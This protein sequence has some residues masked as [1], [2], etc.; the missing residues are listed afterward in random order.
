MD[1]L[2]LQPL[3]PQEV[4]VH[5]VRLRGPPVQEVLLPLEV[6]LDQSDPVDLVNLLL[7]VLPNL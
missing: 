2:D 7:V 6:R 3:E 1:L 5:P 4:L